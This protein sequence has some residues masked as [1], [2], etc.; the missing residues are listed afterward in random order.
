MLSEKGDPERRSLEAL[1]DALGFRL[2]VSPLRRS[3]RP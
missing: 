1:L 3:S 2:T